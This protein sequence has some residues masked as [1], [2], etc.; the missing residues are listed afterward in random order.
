MVDLVLED[1]AHELVTCVLDGVTVEDTVNTLTRHEGGAMGSYSLNLYQHPNEVLMTVV[2]ERGTLR[3]DYA[4]QRWSWMTDPN[5]A[6]HHESI[7]VPDRDTIYRI[8]NAAFL[9]AVE[10]CG[11][12]LCSLGDAVRTLKVNL[13]SH[14]SA[15]NST[16]ENSLT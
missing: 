5:G 14:R 9:D 12:V 7:E 3:A 15:K 6:W 8:Q 2:C 11:D 4:N 10:G 1:P 16:W 13:A